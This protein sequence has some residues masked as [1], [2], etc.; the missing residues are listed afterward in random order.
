MLRLETGQLS[1]LIIINYDRDKSRGWMKTWRWSSFYERIDFQN[2]ER[3]SSD[4]SSAVLFREKNALELS[5]E[6][7]PS[8]GHRKRTQIKANIF[9][10]NTK[11]IA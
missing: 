4:A 5:S 6:R 9:R 2:V 10:K 1:E 11:L 7:T 8:V 3:A